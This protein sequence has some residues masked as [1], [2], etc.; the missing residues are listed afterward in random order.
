MTGSNRLLIGVGW[1]AVVFIA[2]WRV[3]RISRAR[4]YTGPVD[5]DVLLDRSHS[6]EIAFL[7]IAAL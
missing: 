4:G 5:T 7:A 3:T 2:A 1:S 6:I